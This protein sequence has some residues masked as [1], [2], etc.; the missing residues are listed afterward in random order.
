MV[1]GFN[2]KSVEALLDKGE[3]KMTVYGLGRVSLPLTVA[4]AQTMSESQV[5]AKTSQ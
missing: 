3:V 5:V 4:R 2:R 1:L